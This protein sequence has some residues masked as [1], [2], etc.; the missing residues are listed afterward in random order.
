MSR[1]LLTVY[2]VG[3]MQ[4]NS[5]FN[6]TKTLEFTSGKKKSNLDGS[7]LLFLALRRQRQEQHHESMGQPGL[8][9]KVASK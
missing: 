7:H 3:V 8:N 1:G 2:S 6:R 4:I 5:P 9:S